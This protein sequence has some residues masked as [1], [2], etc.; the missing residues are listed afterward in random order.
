[1]NCQF[2]TLALLT[3][4]AIAQCVSCL[5]TALVDR[6]TRP[7]FGSLPLLAHVS[8]SSSSHI[9]DHAFGRQQAHDGYSFNSTDPHLR[10]SEF[11]FQTYDISLGLPYLPTL[12]PREPCWTPP[13]LTSCPRSRLRVTPERSR[14]T[15][16]LPGIWSPT[17][18]GTIAKRVKSPKPSLLNVVVSST[19]ST[20]QFVTPRK[21]WRPTKSRGYA[22]SRSSVVR[23][24]SMPPFGLVRRTKRNDRSQVPRPDPKVP[25]RRR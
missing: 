18:A 15:R 16:S 12:D 3:L 4:T 7:A 24:F 14:L 22:P 11:V 17:D 6:L 23:R 1:M 21:T 19:T 8:S 20:R 10:P 2:D 5:S 25:P 9:L 13:N